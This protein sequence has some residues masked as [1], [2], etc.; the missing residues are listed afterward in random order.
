MPPHAISAPAENGTTP[1]PPAHRDG[2]VLRWLGAYTASMVGSN[3]Y[4][5]AL[6]W[7]AARTGSPAQAGLVLAVGSV[8]RAALMLGGGVVADRFGPRLVVIGSDAARCVFIL[9]MAAVLLFISPSVWLLAGVALVFGAVDALFLPAVGALPPRITAPGQLVRVQGMSGLATRFANVAGAPIGGLTV[10]LGGSASAFTAAGVLF[11]VS[12][13]L[14]LSVRIGELPGARGEKGDRAEEALE[15]GEESP[16][17]HDVIPA[18]RDAADA[19]RERPDESGVSPAAEKRTGGTD[20]AAPGAGRALLDGLRYIRRHRVLAPLILVSAI[21]QLG[22]VGP[23]NIGL[24]LVSEE[25]GWGA[26]GLG[27]IIAAFSAG[28]A[29]A[30]LLLTVRGRVPRAGFVMCASTIIGSVAIACIAYAPSVALASVAAVC[31]G[32]LAGLGGALSGALVQ[33]QTEPA[34]LGRVTSVS[35]LFGLGIAPLV[36]PVMGAAIGAWGS[37]PVFVASAALCAAG[38]TFG[39]C[40]KQLRRAELPT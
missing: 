28:A 6:A 23:L 14:L 8:P 37:G 18:P 3:V 32:L 39:L 7:A 13:P 22:F 40:V 25:H 35:T 1:P 11:A 9:G 31:V 16:V 30:S 12:L 20:P 27:W 15:A 29:G 5:V 4:F 33:T 21:T 24:V 10:A 26:S 2:N 38:T 36:Y 19:R 34:Y 17:P